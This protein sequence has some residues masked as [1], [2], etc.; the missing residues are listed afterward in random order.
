LA[1]E[2]RFFMSE[3]D[4]RELLRRLE[5]LRLE[6]WPV[7]SDAG[8]SAPLVSAGTELADAAYYLAAGDVTGYPIKKGKERGKWKIDEV[9]SP[10]IYFLRSVRD[11]DGGLRS[12]YFWAE[13]EA[14]GDNA[15]TGGKP[16]A[17]LRAVRELQELIKSRYRRSS[18]VHGLTYFVGPAC[19]RMGMPLREEGRK[20]ESVVVYR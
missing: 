19:A 6:L 8:F 17:F 4:E 18:P 2:I 13:T 12:G 7:F 11:E 10:V 3:E 14:A 16:V 9:I 15:R 20:G 1:L 5:P